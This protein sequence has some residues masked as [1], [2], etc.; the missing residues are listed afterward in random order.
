MDNSLK[1][2][3]ALLSVCYITG[4]FLTGCGH[5]SPQA[6]QPVVNI[7]VADPD[8]IRFSGK[9]AGAGMMMAGAMGPMGIAIG[10][11]IDEGIGK[12]ID[13]TARRGNVDIRKLLVDAVNTQLGKSGFP[14]AGREVAVIDVV[15]ER[16]GF[17]TAPGEGDLVQAQLHIRFQLNDDNGKMKTIRL[18][19]DFRNNDIVFATYPLDDIKTDA[20]K[21]RRAL[22]EASEFLVAVGLAP[23]TIY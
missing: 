22:A 14:V 21:I 6:R 12:D 10:V 1:T 18:P 13:E 19:E 11:A 20:E 16:Y 7:K 2:W 5:I 17:I 3:F 9:G 15:V 4:M 23:N 8:R